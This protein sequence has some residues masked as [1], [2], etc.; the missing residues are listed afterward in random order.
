[1][2][3]IMKHTLSLLTAKESVYLIEF[4]IQHRDAPVWHSFCCLF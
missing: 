4:T 1:M 2:P 3:L